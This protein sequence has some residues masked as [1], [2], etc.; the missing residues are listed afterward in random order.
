MSDRIESSPRPSFFSPVPETSSPSG[1]DSLSAARRRAEHVIRSNEDSF[2]DVRG[3]R[4][5][6]SSIGAAIEEFDDEVFIHT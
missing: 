3:A 2:F 5:P 1:D 6:K 4:V